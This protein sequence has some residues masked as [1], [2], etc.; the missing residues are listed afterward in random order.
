MGQTTS[1][2]PKIGFRRPGMISLMALSAALT[3]VLLLVAV[4]AR[5]VLSTKAITHLGPDGADG[6][7]TPMPMVW[8][9]SLVGG[10]VA[11]GVLAFIGRRPITWWDLAPKLGASAVLAVAGAGWGFAAGIEITAFAADTASGAMPNAAMGGIVGLF[12]GALILFIASMALT[13]SAWTQDESGARTD[14]PA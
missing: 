4:L 11:A 2:Q 7:G 3:V 6:F 9:A 14:R 10:V 1:A 13:P 8:A 5:D 12:A